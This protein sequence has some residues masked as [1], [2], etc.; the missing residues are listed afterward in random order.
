MTGHQWLLL[1]GTA[2][3][4]LFTGLLLIDALARG[5]PKGRCWRQ[6]TVGFRRVVPCPTQPKDAAEEYQHQTRGLRLNNFSPKRRLR[7]KLLVLAVLVILNVVSFGLLLSRA[8]GEP[9]VESTSTQSAT[10]GG[11]SSSAGPSPP[12]ARERFGGG[13]DHSVGGFRRLR[14]ALPNRSNPR[15]V[16]RW[17][18]HLSAGAALGGWQVA[19][20]PGTHQ[21][22]PVGPVHRLCRAWAAGSLPASRAGP[23]LRR[24]V[25]TLCAG[26]HGLTTLAISHRPRTAS[27]L[28]KTTT[29]SR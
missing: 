9:A 29:L 14:Q 5:R 27:S 20:L 17:S 28:A 22:R 6:R 7:L 16:P 13:A 24:D 18:R 15:Y 4:F 8:P 26:D 25:Q 23:R 11:L 3:T 19:G 2:V 12:R 1:I 10:P 21:D